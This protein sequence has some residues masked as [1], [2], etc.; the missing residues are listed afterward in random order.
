MEAAIKR[1]RNGTAAGI[2]N[3]LPEMLKY[4][5]EAAGEWLHRVILLAWRSES[6]PAV[7]SSDIIKYMHKKGDSSECDNHR[8]ITL[9]SVIGKVYASIIR[10]RLQQWLEAQL[11]EPQCGF[12]PGRGCT[13]ALFTLR[14]LAEQC[15][16]KQQL[17]FCCFLDLS[18][19]FDSADRSILWQIMESR[20]APA[21]LI[22]LIKNLHDSHRCVV[23][24]EQ[25]QSEWF[26]VSTGVKQGDVLAPMLFNLYMDT[27]VQQLLPQLQA[28]GASIWYSLDGQLTEARHPTHEQLL[29]ILLYADDAVLMCRTAEQLQ[30]AVLATDIAFTQWGLTISVPKT[31]V[32]TLGRNGPDASALDIRCQGQTLEVVDQFKYLGSMVANDGS[33]DAEIANRVK[34]AG[35]AFHSLKQAKVWADKRIATPLKLKVYATL[36]L[37]I[38]LYACET[39]AALPEHVQRLEVFHMRCL[40]TICCLSLRDHISNVDI[41]RQCQ[42][43]S[44]AST[45]QQRRLRW[46]GHVGRMVDCRLPKRMLF[47]QVLGRRPRGRPRKRWRDIVQVDLDTMFS[48]RQ[49]RFGRYDWSSVC[50][51]R[52]T[53][54]Q[55]VAGV[56]TRS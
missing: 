52:G 31:K 30:A 2:C 56:R 3:T 32:L 11:L 41:L 25:M 13:D 21:K 28:M 40:R 18:K 37:S 29:W 38:L 27:I 50:Q 6:A 34:L 7:F 42:M 1:L 24:A 45:L 44:I 15:M 47:G 33:I 23:R 36:V 51:D 17:M 12:R 53:W 26:S 43:P 19:A 8:T 54:R 16:E 48:A 10:A 14:Q 4:G 20:G 49:G 39:W 22:A 55:L 5:G 46:L 35:H 9:Q